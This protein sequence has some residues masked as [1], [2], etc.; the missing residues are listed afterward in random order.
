M[1]V[2]PGKAQR[3]EYF[4]AGQYIPGLIELW[5]WAEAARIMGGAERWQELC[6]ATKAPPFSS[7]LPG[8]FVLHDIAFE[9][10]LPANIRTSDVLGNNA[11]PLHVCWRRFAWGAT[12]A[13][14]VKR[15]SRDCNG[16]AVEVVLGDERWSA[17]E[18][19]KFV[20]TS[21]EKAV[22][23]RLL[24]ALFELLHRD[25]SRDNYTLERTAS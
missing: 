20:F 21:E 17:V 8:T 23:D 25:R 12:C 4:I 7:H 15:Y 14:V 3:Q 11:A 1:H 13:E 6:V 5:L 16:H 9:P 18:M 24:L 22:L 19:Y 10:S 2:P